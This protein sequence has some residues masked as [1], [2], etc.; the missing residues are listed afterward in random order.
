[1]F[2][3]QQVRGARGAAALTLSSEVLP[4]QMVAA[5]FHW[6]AVARIPV[7][8]TAKA[9]PPCRRSSACLEWDPACRPRSRSMAPTLRPAV[10]PSV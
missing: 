6:Q 5:V 1:V 10:P 4:P 7:E 8:P 9:A 2:R 3:H